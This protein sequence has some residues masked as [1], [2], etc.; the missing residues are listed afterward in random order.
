MKN[1]LKSVAFLFFTIT[2]VLS[3]CTSTYAQ[4][5]DGSITIE[6]LNQKISVIQTKIE[7]INY[8]I[9]QIQSD[10]ANS[11]QI[12][13]I[14]RLNQSKIDLSREL[15]KLE[16]IKISVEYADQN[17]IIEKKNSG[18]SNPHIYT[19]VVKTKI[20]Q[21][22]FNVLPEVKKQEILAHPEQYE[23]IN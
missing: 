8:R 23:I 3:Y 12:D 18:D 15:E 16:K 2:F 21:T 10:P 7:S 9:T 19:P 17:N 6:S 14:N 13:Y 5:D 22:D 11:E 20:S 4:V 1:L